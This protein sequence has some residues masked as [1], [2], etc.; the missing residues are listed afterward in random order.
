MGLITASTHG[1][2]PALGTKLPYDPINDFK[3][4]SM[5]GDAPYVLV[6]YPGIPVKSVSE[7][8]A[9]AKTKPGHAQLRLGRLASL[10]HL[11]ARAVREPDA[12]IELTHVPYEARRNPRST[13]SP[14]ASTC[15][16]P[17]SGRRWR[18]SATAS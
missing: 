15:S 13:S 5:I 16:S 2:A 11:A 7:L 17:P 14:A 12:G 4:V 18:T 3:P 8:V 6:L 1:V 9:L 10:A